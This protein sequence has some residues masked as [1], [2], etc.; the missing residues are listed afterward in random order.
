[1]GAFD[2]GSV[3]IIVGDVDGGVDGTVA[4]NVVVSL[5]HL[6]A[7]PVNISMLFKNP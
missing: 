7:L 1:M 6:S 3:S 2:D 4:G 5:N